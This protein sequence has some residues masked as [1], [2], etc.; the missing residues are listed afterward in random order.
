MSDFSPQKDPMV[1]ITLMQPTPI[2][3]VPPLQ[4]APVFAPSQLNPSVNDYPSIGNAA[5]ASVSD[6][7]PTAGDFLSSPFSLPNAGIPSVELELETDAHSG[8]FLQSPTVGSASNAPSTVYSTT[9]TS[10]DVAVACTDANLARPET[11]VFIYSLETKMRDTDG[12]ESV[13]KA[14]EKALNK[15][16]ANLLLHCDVDLVVQADSVLGFEG[17]DYVPEDSIA[18]EGKLRLSILLEMKWN[19]S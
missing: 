13:R 5:P 17:I 19:R 1:P 15:D 2:M 12:I 16:I 9:S 7:S 6:I 3:P 4:L 10:E 14:T 8:S 11:V 18:E